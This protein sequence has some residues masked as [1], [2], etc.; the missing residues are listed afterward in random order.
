MI[1]H[2]VLALYFVNLKMPTRFHASNAAIK[3]AMK[4]SVAAEWNKQLTA[5]YC[6]GIK[7][8]E[9]ALAQKSYKKGLIR[10]QHVSSNP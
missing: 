7:E 1:S 10:R 4:A 3:L 6:L 8:L 9:P 5:E 2:G